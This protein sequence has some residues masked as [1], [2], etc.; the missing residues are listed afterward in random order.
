MVKSCCCSHWAAYL[1]SAGVMLIDGVIGVPFGQAVSPG[2]QWPVMLHCASPRN[3][4]S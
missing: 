4:S 1:M 2:V 3:M